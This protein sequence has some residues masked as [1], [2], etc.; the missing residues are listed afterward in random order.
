M[1]S[2]SARSR[3]GQLDDSW[4]RF[5]PAGRKAGPSVSSTA[6]WRGS[7]AGAGT[8]HERRTGLFH[9]EPFRMK[10][11]ILGRRARR[12]MH[13]GDEAAAVRHRRRDVPVDAQARGRV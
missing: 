11:P 7:Y 5:R 6:A 13:D 1:I 9:L 3:P 12:V 8:G 4:T 10:A 2:V